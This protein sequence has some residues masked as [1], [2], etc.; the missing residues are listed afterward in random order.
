MRETKKNTCASNS[1]EARVY[2][3]PMN[4]SLSGEKSKYFSTLCFEKETVRGSNLCLQRLK[5]NNNHES[6]SQ[7][8]FNARFTRTQNLLME[9]TIVVLFQ[10]SFAR[11]PM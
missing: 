6:L 3:F 1:F 7:I 9:N 2:N 4:S 5:T 11:H 10:D 8:K